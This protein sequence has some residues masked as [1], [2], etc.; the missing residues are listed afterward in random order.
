MH[1]DDQAQNR[2]HA[3]PSRVA[4]EIWVWNGAHEVQKLLMEMHVLLSKEAGL[5]D[6]PQRPGEIK[7]R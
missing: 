5:G 7:R 4:A 3:P 1:A 2:T 6:T